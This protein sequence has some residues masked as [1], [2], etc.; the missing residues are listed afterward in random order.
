VWRS[1]ADY[2]RRRRLLRIGGIAFLLL[3]LVAAGWYI[4]TRPPTP[5]N[6]RVYDAATGHKLWSRSVDGGY[7]VVIAVTPGAALVADADDC[8][9]G[10][11][12]TVEL[13]TPGKT[14]FI[15][16]VPGCSVYRFTPA[17]GVYARQV[18]GPPGRL[19]VN[20]PAQLGR[21][22]AVLPCP[23]PGSVPGPFGES[24]SPVTRG[25]YA[26]VQ[27]GKFVAGAD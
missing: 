14:T 21:G 17:T 10:G 20:V 9:H 13:L 6:V 19:I 3:V 7:V 2:E 4:R 24:G 8:I 15:A 1:K 23:C 27:L 5:G 16:T 22:T 25:A 11:P 26:R 18:A 12:G